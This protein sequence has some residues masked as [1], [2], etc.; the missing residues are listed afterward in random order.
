MSNIL[1]G[2]EVAAALSARIKS[3]VEKLALR[4]ITPTL[5]IIRAGETPGDLSY[6]KGIEK[7]CEA[8]SVRVV[9]E[10]LPADVSQ[11]RLT[12]VIKG[13]NSNRDI[14]GVLLFRPLPP[15]LDRQ[16]AEN[17][18]DAG[19]DVDCMT[20]LSLAGIFSGKSLG[21]APCTAQ[22][23]ME[24]L[25]YYG[26]DCTGKKAVV[27]GRSLVVGKPAAM[28]LLSKNATVTVCHTKTKDL[29]LIAREADILIAAAGKAR[30][31]GADYLREG[32]IV[33]DVGIH[34]DPDGRLC[35][36]VDG[37][38]ASMA[39]CVYTPVPGGVGAVTSTVL[40]SHVAAAALSQMEK[41]FD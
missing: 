35:G 10:Q 34:T 7:R 39:G 1:S 36:D 14:N 30:M 21:F 12:E 9:K 18:L 27:I 32:Q 28:M 37:Q 19:K 20:D 3:Q 29:P 41:R 15:H 13:A 8:L 25:D 17:M 22:A 5:M 6:E 4:Q 23:C 16:K 38:A 24:I 2:K 31:I 26:I 11:E 40:V 33:L